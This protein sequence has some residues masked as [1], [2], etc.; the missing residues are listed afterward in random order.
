MRRIS[1]FLLFSLGLACSAGAV[2]D[3]L[4]V[5]SDQ[6]ASAV[7]RPAHGMVMEQVLQQHG[8]PQ[9]RLGPVGEPP[10]SH[11]VYGDFIVYFEHQ[12]V[13][14]SVVPH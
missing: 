3:T 13:I 9:Q 12:H 7:V 2:G 5:K 6:S 14:H 10:I 4:L 1:F 8:E 11:W